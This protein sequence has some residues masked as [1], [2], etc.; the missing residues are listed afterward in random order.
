[1]NTGA[2]NW[3]YTVLYIS[4]YVW[5][6][7]L[8]YLQL[9]VHV[10]YSC[11]VVCSI[12]ALDWFWI[13]LISDRYRMTPDRCSEQCASAKGS[14]QAGMPS[15]GARAQLQISTLTVAARS[16]GHHFALRWSF[17]T[18]KTLDFWLRIWYMRVVHESESER[19]V[20]FFFLLYMHFGRQHA[21]KIEC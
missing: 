1:M 3:H 12:L 17:G 20:D 8:Q 11:S 5:V 18:P 10:R 15:T 13:L 21:V 6:L 9:Y 14:Q 4:L 2:Y 19:A 7:L 16:A